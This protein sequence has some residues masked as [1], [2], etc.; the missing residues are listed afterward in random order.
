M[1]RLR[2]RNSK[3]SAI[4]A[5]Y[6]YYSYLNV[7]MRFRAGNYALTGRQSF[8]QDILNPEELQGTYLFLKIVIAFFAIAAC[9]ICSGAVFEMLT[10]ESRKS[11]PASV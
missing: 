5:R 11:F 6:C 9:A 4:G 2:L 10:E 8:Q 3:M 7:L 1:D